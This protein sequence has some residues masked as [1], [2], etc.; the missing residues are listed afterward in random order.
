[1]FY[2]FRIFISGALFVG[3]VG[4]GKYDKAVFEAE[5]ATTQLRAANLERDVA[6]AT[7]S[8]RE[9]TRH[10]LDATTRARIDELHRAHADAEVRAALFHDLSR[11]L[12]PVVDA[13]D[14]SI[15]V[16][17]GRM[18]L[19][20]SNDV[21]F[22]TGSTKIKPAGQRT[23]SSVAQEVRTLKD[24]H[25]Q[26]AGHADSVPIHSAKFASNWELS[27]ARALEVVHL[28]VA[29]GV[30]PDVLSAAGYG[31]VDPV[32][33]NNT[34]AGKAKNRRMEITLQPKL[35]E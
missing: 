4:Q 9:R 31:D 32:A 1:M 24:R 19:A 21:L 35:E 17:D 12:Q 33:P 34:A 16:R 5:A 29:Q 8:A 20:L 26:V 27:S 11:R 30:D 23:L 18:I 28:L 2:S 25:L 14:L 3:C 10:E 7:L 22:D 6:K 15:V 13:G